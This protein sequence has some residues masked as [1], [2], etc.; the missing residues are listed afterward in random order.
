MVYDNFFTQNYSCE[1]NQKEIY[2]MYIIY[3]QDIK[4]KTRKLK[5]A[6]S[7]EVVSNTLIS[8]LI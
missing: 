8:V 2:T 5:E 7:E 1:K 4:G 6:N 3:R